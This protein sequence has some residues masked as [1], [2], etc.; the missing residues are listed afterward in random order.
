MIRRYQIAEGA[1]VPV[2]TEDAPVLLYVNPEAAERDALRTRFQLDEH[3]LSSALDPDEVSRLETTAERT[4]KHRCSASQLF[5]VGF[6]C[7][8]AFTPAFD[9]QFGLRTNGGIADRV[10]LD[11]DYDTQREFDGSNQISIAYRGT[12]TSRLQKLEVGNVF[13]EPPA[14]RFISAP[15]RKAWK[16][17]R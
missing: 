12:P 14:S 5:S 3:T 8:S 1:L 6:T 17:A 16:R 11:V 2:D 9:A 10:K 13:F 7:R 4:Q 15:R